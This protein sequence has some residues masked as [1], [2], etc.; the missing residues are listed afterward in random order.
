MKRKQGRNKLIRGV[1]MKIFKISKIQA[2]VI[3]GLNQRSM[4]YY[5]KKA[6]L[7]PTEKFM[8]IT[9]RDLI[10]VCQKRNW[11]SESV[12]QLFIILNNGLSLYD[13]NNIQ[14]E[15]IN[16][17]KDMNAFKKAVRLIKYWC[18]KQLNYNMY[19]LILKYV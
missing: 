10:R 18:E 19:K 3:I 12:E 6:G 9:D 15:I 4:T 14:A 8:F 11:K 1:I 13:F 16:K 17:N 2:D 5:S 7:L